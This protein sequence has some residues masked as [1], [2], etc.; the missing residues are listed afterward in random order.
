[1]P[2]KTIAAFE[3]HGCIVDNSVEQRLPEAERVMRDFERL[4][5]SFDQVT[6]Q[7]E[8][9]GIEKFIEAYDG[10]LAQLA[11]QRERAPDPTKEARKRE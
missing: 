10:L 4:G 3:H 11:V 5:I 7:L 8:S 2:E 6:A 9:E 1:M